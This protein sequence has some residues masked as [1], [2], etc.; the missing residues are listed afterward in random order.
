LEILS[1]L[2]LNLLLEEDGLDDVLEAVR[3]VEARDV[4]APPFELVPPDEV[5]LLGD[6]V[7]VA[8]LFDL[9][10]NLPPL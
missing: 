4:P 1:K 10:L 5:E 6:G 7:R 2:R 3:L 9:A 8:V